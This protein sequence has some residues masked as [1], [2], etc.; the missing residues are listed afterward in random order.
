MNE[1]AEPSGAP[2]A[3]LQVCVWKSRG[4]STLVEEPLCCGVFHSHAPHRVPTSVLE[5]VDYSTACHAFS[6]V[7]LL[8]LAW[9]SWWVRG[10]LQPRLLPY[11]RAAWSTP[12]LAI[13]SVA[14]GRVL[15]HTVLHGI[16]GVDAALTIPAPAAGHQVISV[17]LLLNQ[18]GDG[19]GFACSLL[20]VQGDL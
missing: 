8:A 18:Y 6:A 12:P 7:C 16:P 1:R 19:S 9:P 5:G 4:D 10:G 14:A 13:L 20:S 3:G 2:A 15:C 17:P 11:T